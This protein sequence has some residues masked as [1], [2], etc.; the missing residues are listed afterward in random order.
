MENKVKVWIAR[1]ESG[2][3]FVHFEKPYKSTEKGLGEWVS[4]GS[5]AFSKGFP[6]VKWED[7]EPTEAYIALVEPQ[8]QPKK[9]IDW[10]QRRYDV[11][12]DILEKI[13]YNADMLHHNEFEYA[14]TAI[15]VANALIY[16]LK[17]QNI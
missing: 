14:Q 12:K 11:A 6:S 4:H 1:D 7:D 5:K 9:E 2:Y 3:A 10:E 8:E 16:K 13:C 15:D 17:K